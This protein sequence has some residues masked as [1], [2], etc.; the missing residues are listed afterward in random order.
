M[1][2]VKLSVFASEEMQGCQSDGGGKCSHLYRPYSTEMKA[3]CP[4]RDADLSSHTADS[5]SHL[6]HGFQYKQ[7]L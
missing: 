1:H 3:I 4:V 7:S 6:P 5:K 2:S